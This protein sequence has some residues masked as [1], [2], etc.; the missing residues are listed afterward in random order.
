MTTLMLRREISRHHG[1][2]LGAPVGDPLRNWIGLIP[3]EFQRTE[4][5]MVLWDPLRGSR[6]VV[7][8]HTPTLQKVI[9]FRDALGRAGG[10]AGRLY[11]TAKLS[12]A[13]IS[14]RLALA[15]I[16]HG[17]T[18]LDLR[19]PGRAEK[20][21]DP[22]LP[23]V[24][25]LRYTMPPTA[26]VPYEDMIRKHRDKIRDVLTLL[27]NSPGPVLVHC[28]EGKDRTGIIVG[29]VMLCAGYGEKAAHNEFLRTMGANRR[30]WNKMLSAMCW[31]AMVTDP[32]LW[33]TSKTGLALDT[34]TA[35]RLKQRYSSAP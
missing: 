32:A 9:E 4:H 29:L 11:R 7:N 5:G 1:P 22:V 2:A 26:Y 27:A 28:T 17:G 33:L 23:G 6:T 12:E 31:D 20:E 21:P 19:T 34:I 10:P 14:D 25:N 35:E 8:P 18:I 3:G 16:L 24:T 15:G 13:T 30:D